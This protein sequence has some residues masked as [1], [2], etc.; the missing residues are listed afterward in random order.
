[1][2][3]QIETS[4]SAFKAKSGDLKSQSEWLESHES[5]Y[6]KHLKKRHVQMM[7]L[8]GAIGTGLFLGAGARLQIAGPALA[9]VYLVCGVFAFFHTQGAW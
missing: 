9:V 3:S 1:M 5:G 6:S 4:Q 7:A 2:K 8:G